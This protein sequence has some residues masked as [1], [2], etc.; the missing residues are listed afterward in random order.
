ML[1]PAARSAAS[2]AMIYLLPQ[3]QRERIAKL[4]AIDNSTR[5]SLA[6]L[7][8]MHS[9]DSDGGNHGRR[10]GQ[11]SSD[12]GCTPGCSETHRITRTLHRCFK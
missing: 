9:T 12:P 6:S 8:A 5:I 3:F 4:H 1:L 11:Q 7:E 10:R 2:L